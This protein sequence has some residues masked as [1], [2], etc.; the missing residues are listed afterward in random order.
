VLGL[1]GWAG[2]VRAAVAGTQRGGMIMTLACAQIVCF[3]IGL[4]FGPALEIFDC[5]AVVLEACPL[6]QAI[7][8]HSPLA[9]V[10]GSR[11]MPLSLAKHVCACTCMCVCVC[12]CMCVVSVCG[13]CMWN[14]T[15]P[16]CHFDTVY[17]FL[18]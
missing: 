7:F 8:R 15:R 1:F 17:R 2:P 4:I 5:L 3:L 9:V 13:V 11:S 18:R 6:C 10:H 16:V 12:V 14:A